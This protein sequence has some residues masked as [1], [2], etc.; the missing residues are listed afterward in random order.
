MKKEK[1]GCFAIYFD[2]WFNEVMDATSGMLAFSLIILPLVILGITLFEFYNVPLFWFIFVPL[3]LILSEIIYIQFVKAFK[4]SIL[5]WKFLGILG[6]LQVISLGL[7]TPFWIIKLIT[8][9]PYNKIWIPCCIVISIVGVIILYF[10]INVMIG[11][12]VRKE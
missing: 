10:W 11:K 5:G 9:V 7:L 3:T 1:K 6:A 2:D 4:G 8:K 12:K